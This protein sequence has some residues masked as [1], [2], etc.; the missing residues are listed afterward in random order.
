M[1]ASGTFET[2]TDALAMAAF[3]GIADIAWQSR[4]RSHALDDE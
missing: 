1:A 2:S 4:V 3:G